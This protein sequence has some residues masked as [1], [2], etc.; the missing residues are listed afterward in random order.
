MLVGELGL[1]YVHNYISQNRKC[2]PLQWMY[3][4]FSV[5]LIIPGT[6][7]DDGYIFFEDEERYETEKISVEK[8]VE[9]LTDLPTSVYFL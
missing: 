7:D 5:R 3:S 8:L 4:K 6:P 1:P 9:K 2:N